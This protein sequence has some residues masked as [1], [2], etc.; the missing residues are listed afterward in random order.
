MK[1]EIISLFRE[2]AM[3]CPDC[4]GQGFHILLDKMGMTYE[5]IVGFECTNPDCRWAM[6][7]ELVGAE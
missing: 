7:I 6:E 2:L 4:R 5:H 1:A 3:T